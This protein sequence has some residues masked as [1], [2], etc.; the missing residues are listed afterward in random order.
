M[1]T[2]KHGLDSTT[3]CILQQ[4]KGNSERLNELKGHTASMTEPGLKFIILRCL[5]WS[6]FQSTCCLFC[7]GF[8]PLNSAHCYS[9]LFTC[10]LNKAKLVSLW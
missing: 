2:Q 6:L 7:N 10:H 5:V 9:T 3:D 4:E 8:Y 1:L